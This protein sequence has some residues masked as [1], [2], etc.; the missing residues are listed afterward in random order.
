[1]KYLKLVLLNITTVILV[2]SIIWLI[3][4][5]SAN[6]YFIFFIILFLFVIII[7][8]TKEIFFKPKRY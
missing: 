4:D 7:Y 6:K 3:F 5:S 8:L 2:G 1:M